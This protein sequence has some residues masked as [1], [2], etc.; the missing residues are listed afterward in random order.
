MADPN[1]DPGLPSAPIQRITKPLADFLHVEAA[2]GLVLVVASALALVLAN[3]GFADVYLGI[4]KAPFSIGQ[5][6]YPTVA[7]SMSTSVESSEETSRTP[8]SD[9]RL[10]GRPSTDSITSRAWSKSCSLPS[11]DCAARLS[12]HFVWSNSRMQHT[13]MSI[14]SIGRTKYL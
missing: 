11:T 6:L 10:K 3:T 12:P 7:V 4:W 2:G 5:S 9:S 1:S 14:P 8:R 13:N